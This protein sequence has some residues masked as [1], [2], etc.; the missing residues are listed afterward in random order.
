M[1][2]ETVQ[3]IHLVCDQ[4]QEDNMIILC[5]LYIVNVAFDHICVERKNKLRL[6]GKAR[7]H[8]RTCMLNVNLQLEREAQVCLLARSRQTCASRSDWRSTAV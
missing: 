7:S 4:E 8:L 2:A 5:V 1:A 6:G 3:F